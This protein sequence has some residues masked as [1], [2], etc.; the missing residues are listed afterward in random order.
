MSEQI[1]YYNPY[2]LLDGESLVPTGNLTE[3]ITMPELMLKY[4]EQFPLPEIEQE[5]E[6]E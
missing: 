3:P 6:N 2:N 4:L 5:P 1:Y